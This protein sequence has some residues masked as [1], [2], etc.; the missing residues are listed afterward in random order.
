MHVKQLDFVDHLERAE[1]ADRTRADAPL[2]VE[3]AVARPARQQRVD[4]AARAAAYLAAV[5]SYQAAHHR[6]PTRRELAAWMRCSPSTVHAAACDAERLRLVDHVWEH[7][8]R[9]RP[10]AILVR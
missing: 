9:R 6:T 4:R 10:R 3:R 7:A 5:K 8:N 2:A 1:L